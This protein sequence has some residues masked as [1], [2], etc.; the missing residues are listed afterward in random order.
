MFRAKTGSN[1]VITLDHAYHGHVMSLMDISP[2]KFNRPGLHSH[3]CL[4]NIFIKT[5]KT[6][7]IW[8]IQKLI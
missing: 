1:E 6:L 7:I 3:I 2:Y 8:N 4:Y 5:Y